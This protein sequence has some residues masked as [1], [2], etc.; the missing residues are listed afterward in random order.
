MSLK[1]MHYVERIAVTALLA[2]TL[3]AYPKRTGDVVARYLLSLDLR[4]I[5]NIKSKR[6]F[7]IW[8]NE[9]TNSLCQMI[10]K[11]TKAGRSPKWDESELFWGVSRKALNIFLMSALYHRVLYREY[12]LG[13]I[14]KYLEVPLDRDVASKLWKNS[15]SSDAPLPKWQ[16]IKS[17]TPK[18]SIQYQEFAHNYARDKKIQRVQIDF[19]FWRQEAREHARPH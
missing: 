19:L 10:W 13:R 7:E 8:L 4:K 9:H 12:G 3:R 5:G 18:I 17:L 16:G 15:K 1:I 14:E 11:K 2:S 6:K